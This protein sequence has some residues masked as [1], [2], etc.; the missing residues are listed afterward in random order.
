MKKLLNKRVLAVMLALVMAFSM[1]AVAFAVTGTGYYLLSDVGTQAYT[2]PI[3]VKVVLD[4]KQMDGMSTNGAV[5]QVYNVTL[6]SVGMSETVFT[7]RDAMLQLCAS[8]TDIICYADSDFNL[9]AGN[10]DYIYAISVGNML[11]MPSLPAAGM[12]LDGW[13]FRINDKIPLES[14]TGAPITNGIK[15][16]DIESAT[17]KNGDVIHFYWNY[18]FQNTATTLYSA[19]YL[20][21]NTTY[22]NGVASVQIVKSDDY[23]DNNSD[24]HISNFTNYTGLGSGDAVNIYDANGVIKGSGTLSA[25][26]SCTVNCTLT[27]GTTYYVAVESQS[28]D[29]VYG[30]DAVYIL[31]ETKVY[32]PFVA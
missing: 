13:Y 10:N 17:V 1:S 28:Y 21:A 12:A 19:K 6:G 26:G 14:L 31:D 5:S 2:A 27:S 22:S 9:L 11:Y 4:S 15:G 29:V 30:D 8:N 25:A 23:F 3:N 16:A 18:P 32:S 20:G 24:W 7:V